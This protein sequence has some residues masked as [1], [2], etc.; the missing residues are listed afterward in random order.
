MYKYIT[1]PTE[2]APVLGWAP[3]I[4]CEHYPCH[5]VKAYLR[6]AACY[7]GCW[8][9]QINHLFARGDKLHFLYSRMT[10]KTVNCNAEEVISSPFFSLFPLLVNY[11]CYK[12]FLTLKSA[13]YSEFPITSFHTDAWPGFFTTYLCDSCSLVDIR[14]L[15]RILFQLLCTELLQRSL[16][17]AN[18]S[19]G[20]IVS[21]E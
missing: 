3:L 2:G 8:L 5:K 1:G 16:E 7:D 12:S 19:F 15:L 18:F 14:R 9:K 4:G 10:D 17:K 20:N 11:L 6:L 21:S 13:Y